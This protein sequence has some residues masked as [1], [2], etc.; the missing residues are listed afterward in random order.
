M[1]DRFCRERNILENKAIALEERLYNDF[2]AGVDI[3]KKAKPKYYP[4]RF[5]EMLQTYGAVGTSKRLL[6]D[7]KEFSEYKGLNR[8][9]E[10]ENFEHIPNALHC[11]VE[12]I[13]YEHEEYWPL[14]TTAE[15]EVCKKR[16]MELGF[17]S[18]I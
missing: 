9:W 10:M 7:G 15:R 14:F 4:T 6:H 12:A 18:D 17:S 11:S 3:F 16:L 13:I 1:S 5:M 2:M 8:L